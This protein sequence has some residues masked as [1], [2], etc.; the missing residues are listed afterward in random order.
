MFT[1]VADRLLLNAL[2]RPN[3]YKEVISS[4][5]IGNRFFSEARKDGYDG[6]ITQTGNV[7]QTANST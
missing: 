6:L 2:L 4:N 3:L 1:S 5:D 7:L